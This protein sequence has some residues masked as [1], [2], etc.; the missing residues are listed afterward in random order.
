MRWIYVS[1]HFDD[2]VYSCGGLIREQ[3][4]RG[5]AVEVWT[6]CAGDPP[7]G[8]LSALAQRIHAEWGTGSAAETVALRRVEDQNALRRVGATGLSFDIPD[9]I[10]RLSSA[11][12]S[13][14]PDRLLGERHPAE[15]GLEREIAAALSQ[16]LGAEDVLVSPLAIGGHV[17]HLL[18]RAA[19]GRLGRPVQYYAEVPYLFNYPEAVA[20]ATIGMRPGLQP[21]PKESLQAWLAGI[22]AYTSQ[23]GVQFKSDTR[24]RTVMREYWER[25]HGIVLWSPA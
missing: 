1:P 16:S 4:R 18:V 14:Y 7:P 15:A 17:D 2:A 6:V 23:L 12:E 19:V 9:C 11:G 25:R 5:L 8:P 20:P 10:Y 3:S 21:V 22:A 13:L 24:M